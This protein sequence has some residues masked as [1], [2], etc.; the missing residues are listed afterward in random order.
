MATGFA[1]IVNRKVA[2][3]KLQYCWTLKNVT[4]VVCSLKAGGCHNI[5]KTMALS[6]NL[7]YVTQC[8][9]LKKDEQKPMRQ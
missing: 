9:Q 2:S 7:G 5:F 1:K 6:K 8:H 4:T 3:L